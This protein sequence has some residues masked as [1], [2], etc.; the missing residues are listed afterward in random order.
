MISA[1]TWIYVVGNYLT[2]QSTTNYDYWKWRSKSFHLSGAVIYLVECLFCQ[3]RR[4]QIATE[5]STTRT[6]K[7]S[8][9]KV[10]DQDVKSTVKMS[11]L[12]LCCIC[13][14]S[15]WWNRLS[16]RTSQVRSALAVC[17]LQPCH[18]AYPSVH[19]FPLSS[20]ATDNSCHVNH[21]PNEAPQGHL[22]ANDTPVRIVTDDC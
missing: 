18:P 16:F 11:P 12:Q 4:I 8:I 21:F 9:L 22:G 20:V 3:C 1:H 6:Q 17:H 7:Q 10:N 14:S 19:P 2:S 5:I 13:H 15:S